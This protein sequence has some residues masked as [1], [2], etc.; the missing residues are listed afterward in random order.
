MDVTSVSGERE[1][2]GVEAEQRQGRPMLVGAT[3]LPYRTPLA[4]V[5]RGRYGSR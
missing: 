3:L 2:E 5:G 4:T 1:R